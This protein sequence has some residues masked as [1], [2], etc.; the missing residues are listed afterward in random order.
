MLLCV[1]LVWPTEFENSLNLCK[2]CL[3]LEN[4]RR[5]VWKSYF[6]ETGFKISVFENHSSHT[7]A[8]YSQ[9]FVIWGVFALK[10]FLFLFY[11]ILFFIYLF[12]WSIEAV[13]QPIKIAIKN[14]VWICLARLM[15]DRSNVIFDRLNLFFD[16]LKIVQRVF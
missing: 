3:K 2:M 7:H 13:A 6:W 4:L 15:L 12:F 9:N 14:L 8:F 16:Q 11:F 5:I 10:C 1:I